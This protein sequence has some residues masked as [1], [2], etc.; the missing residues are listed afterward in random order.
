MKKGTHSSHSV[1]GNTLRAR[2]KD[3]A[4]NRTGNAQSDKKTFPCQK[5]DRDMG[6]H[7]TKKKSKEIYRSE[8]KAVEMLSAKK[9]SGGDGVK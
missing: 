9:R 6:Y 4:K 7:K 3:V 2:R 5:L 8:E 1:R